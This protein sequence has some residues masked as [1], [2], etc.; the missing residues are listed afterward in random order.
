MFLAQGEVVS[1]QSVWDFLAS[2]GPIMIP[3]GLCSVVALAFALERY[4]RL[5]R[6][7]V[8]PASVDPVLALVAEG[9]L[10]EARV[11]A[12]QIDAPAA[13]VLVAGLRRVGRAPADVEKAMEDQARK[14]Y[15][16]LRRNIRPLSIVAAISPLLGLFGTVIGIAEAFHRVVRTGMGKPEHLAAGIEVALVTTIAGLA[17]AIPTL[18][19]AA[20]LTGRARRLMIAIDDRIEPLVEQIA[21]PPGASHAA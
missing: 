20:H 11:A 16:R 3:I 8:L 17:V 14:E 9:R 18:V 4:L 1:L 12:E 2:G 21:A 10:Q 5:T 15:E 19:I 7:Q 13:R 6:R